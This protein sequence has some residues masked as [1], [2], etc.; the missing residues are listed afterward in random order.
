MDGRIP[1]ITQEGRDGDEEPGYIFNLGDGWAAG[2][3][4]FNCKGIKA[5]RVR[6]RGYANGF[7][8]LRLKWDGDPVARIPVQNTNIWTDSAITPVNI[9]DGTQALYI[10]FEGSEAVSLCSFTLYTEETL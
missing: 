4:Y 8:T 7:V 9:P 2:F 3:K 6:T 10:G 5:F 1:K